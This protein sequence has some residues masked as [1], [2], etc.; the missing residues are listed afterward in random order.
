MARIAGLEPER[1]VAGWEGTAFTQDSA[2]HISVWR[3]PA[4]GAGDRDP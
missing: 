1:R 4:R 2:K 3:K